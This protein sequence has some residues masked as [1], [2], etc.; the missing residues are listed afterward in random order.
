MY[1]LDQVH[2]C[3][4]GRIGSIARPKWEIQITSKAYGDSPISNTADRES[5]DSRH[6]DHGKAE[7]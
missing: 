6:Y 5:N 2:V 1:V 3:L 4:L 7:Q